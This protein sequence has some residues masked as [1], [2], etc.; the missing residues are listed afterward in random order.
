MIG[1]F[2]L[3]AFSTLDLANSLVI[4]TLVMLVA[5]C[6]E[7]SVR[8]WSAAWRHSILLLALVVCLV[9]PPFQ[10]AAPKLRMLPSIQLS[11]SP[12]RDHR[13]SSS[14]VEE[15]PV[16]PNTISA[17]AAQDPEVRVES[18][19]RVPRKLS[20][21]R[22]SK[23]FV[24]WLV[25]ICFVGI[26]CG[27][28]RLVLSHLHLL[29][30]VRDSKQINESELLDHVEFAARKLSLASPPQVVFNSKV[31]LPFACGVFRP[32]VVI[33]DD[34]LRRPAADQ[35]G[36]LL[37]EFG[38][39]ARRDP[40]W[41]WLVGLFQAF[42]W[43]HPLA[44]LFTSRLTLLREQ[45][46]DDLVLARCDSIPSYAK[47]LVALAGLESQSSPMAAV[48]F[49]SSRKVEQR[50]RQLFARRVHRNPVS[51]ER[52]ALLMVCF[53][54]VLIPLS[55]LRTATAQQS[56][57]SSETS[58][59]NVSNLIDDAESTAPFNLSGVVKSQT[60]EPIPRA[61]VI[62]ISLGLDEY[63]VVASTTT[64]ENGSYEFREVSLPLTVEDLE[65]ERYLGGFEVIALADSFAL[66]WVEPKYFYP[67]GP[68]DED[69]SRSKD[70]PPEYFDRNDQVVVDVYL[71]KPFPFAGQ[72]ADDDGKP[73]SGVKLSVRDFYADTSSEK[74]KQG[75][76]GQ[77]PS[78]NE[79][80]IIPAQAQACV[81]D[82]QGKFAFD[83]LPPGFRWRV[84]INGEGLAGRGV[85]LV[86]GTRD[87][88]EDSDN[89]YATGETIVMPRPV[90]VPVMVIYGDNRRPAQD[91]FVEMKN[92]N[93]SGGQW[94][95]TEE[96]GQCVLRVPPGKCWV[97]ILPA[98]RTPY[99]RTRYEQV[100]VSKTM[101][102]DSSPLIFE[103]QPAATLDVQVIDAKTKKPLDGYHLFRERL[104]PQPKIGRPLHNG[105]HTF[106]SYERA[107]NLSHNNH[108]K[109]DKDGQLRTFFLS[110]RYR[111]QVRP[112]ENEPEQSE[113]NSLWKTVEL[114][115]G[116]TSELKFEVGEADQAGLW[117]TQ[118]RVQDAT[119]GAPIR[120]AQIEVRL[121]KDDVRLKETN[122]MGECTIVLPSS[123]PKYC[124]VKCRAEG[125]T[126]LTGTWTNYEGRVTDPL[127]TLLNLKM[128]KGAQAGG[129][130]VDD[131][132]K[133]VAD[134]TVSFS[135]SAQAAS[136]GKRISERTSG[137]FKTN[138]EGRWSCPN[139]PREFDDVSISVRHPDFAI[140]TTNYGGDQQIPDLRDETHR[141]HL[142]KGVLLKG[143]VVNW[144]G[145]PI[146]GAVLCVGELNAFRDQGP[147]ATTD[148][149]GRYEFKPLARSQFSR[150]DP[151]PIRVA[152][153][154]PGYAPELHPIP[155]STSQAIADAESNVRV[156]DFLLDP[157]KVVRLK[158]TD[159][160]G[161]PL[162]GVWVIPSQWRNTDA[163]GLLFRQLEFADKTNDQG[164]WEWNS[165]PATDVQ[166]DFVKSGYMSVR[167]QIMRPDAERIHEIQFRRPQM[168]F[169]K[170]TDAETGKLVPQF[171]IKKGWPEI[172]DYWDSFRTTGKD[173]AYRLKVT[174]PAK[175][176]HYRVTADGY[177]PSISR[178]IAVSEGETELNFKLKR[179]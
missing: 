161:K 130:V 47:L 97:G 101:R 106:R 76:F 100:D 154:K 136:Q 103:L 109:T 51:L 16:A 114:E 68:K 2:S 150:A 115:A 14:A 12:E 144:D 72:L 126:S 50:I 22:A 102:A 139:A 135:A 127:P 164:V 35:R 93:G 30:L 24:P 151:W 92:E 152:V 111:L 15:E 65:P 70:L 4:V 45:A 9:I 146:K 162:G 149:S 132:G 40:L 163:L 39:V 82:E 5:L 10:I 53:L 41:Q 112:D 29:R 63:R 27:V 11:N 133:P 134:A 85:S 73:L 170:V 77:L 75:Y 28:M 81:T 88:W 116:K 78:L 94:R 141:L 118:F 108:V 8:R 147:F 1:N 52:I 26:G 74:P 20:S 67:N 159:S 128:S 148:E 119:S 17:T 38:H 113:L 155:N 131:H 57:N 138:A 60:N 71:S 33:G 44:W 37:H 48:A 153:A 110:G 84:V 117:P 95:V 80:S 18:A 55:L 7:R 36:I 123:T 156:V 69:P 6:I 160:D 175:A 179:R 87:Q 31:H 158:A 121:S 177:E 46:C 58:E 90:E 143:R 42:F 169:G 171:L 120:T 137:S 23:D 176:Y 124:A 91:V 79:S 145:R 140:D 59:A 105:L 62:L 49:L 25:A 3:I 165:A 56:D 167:D 104:D 32:T 174:M 21:P 43:F 83:H 13:E 142:S 86:T 98:Y 172:A 64:D 96:D 61:K 99:W 125:Y 66:G 157:G 129:L 107:T 178:P 54:M 89:L 168:M 19:T 173:G 34:V 166:F 122:E